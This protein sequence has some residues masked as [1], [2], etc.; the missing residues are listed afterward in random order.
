M[1]K[2]Q[3]LTEDGQVYLEA[4]EEVFAAAWARVCDFA[5]SFE[6]FPGDFLVVVS[7]LREKV[8]ISTFN[9]E[10]WVLNNG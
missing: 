3:R 10:S 5:E 9:G 2:V 1:W 4:E 6:A 7:P 8:R